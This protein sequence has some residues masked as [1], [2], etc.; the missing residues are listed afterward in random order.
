M[1][2]FGAERRDLLLSTLASLAGGAG[3]P[4]VTSFIRRTLA[5][6]NEATMMV[7]IDALTINE[8]TFFRNVPQLNLFARIALPEM[9]AR[10]RTTGEP[11]Q[12]RLW[13]AGCS[14]GQEAYTLAMLATDAVLSQ[15]GW[16]VQ[17]RATD[18]SPT[19][20][21][22]ARRGIYPK[23]RLDTMPGPMRSRYFDDLGDRI[24]VKDGLRRHITFQ[25][26][27][28]RDPFPADTFDCIF[29]RNVMIY[30]SREEQSRLAHRFKERLAPKGFLFIG[31]SESLQGLGVGLHLRL[32][33]GGVAYQKES[34]EKP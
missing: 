24:R 25:H 13:S 21:D 23:A 15:P 9:I 7:L 22:A 10:K 1:M 5:P 19:V 14:T 27:N 30:F 4:D 28:L 18:L 20:L 8:T 17:I 34:L 31:H 6:G 16:E 33:E 11:K 3:D 12:L 2:Q 26:H 32:H 29:C